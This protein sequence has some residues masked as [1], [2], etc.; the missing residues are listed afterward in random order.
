MAGNIRWCS[1][2]QRGILSRINL[3]LFCTASSECHAFRIKRHGVS[4]V[5]SLVAALRRHPPRRC[6]LQGRS[7]VSHGAR[8]GGREAVFFQWRRRRPRSGMRSFDPAD[9]AGDA[10]L[11]DSCS[12]R[13]LALSSASGSAGALGVRC[14][15]ASCSSP[16][17]SWP[18][19]RG[20][21]ELLG[22]IARVEGGRRS[23]RLPS[24]S[25]DVVKDGT[26]G[27]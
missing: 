23:D 9:G 16:A 12:F 14:A 17:R 3:V 19:C 27:H 21:F 8:A 6:H 18:S 11:N 20:G 4:F 26:S 22:G 10:G 24:L 7:C 1:R 25:G 2:L 5:D 15:P 13:L